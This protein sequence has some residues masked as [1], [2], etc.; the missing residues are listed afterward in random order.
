MRA[1]LKELLQLQEVDTRLNAVRARVAT[2]PQ[3]LAEVNARLAA[4]KA[5]LEKGKESHSTALKDRKKHELDVEQWKEKARKYRD[6]A[7]QVKTNEA[8]KALQHEAEMAEAEIA[9]S[10]DRLL[11]QMVSSEQYDRQVKSA[12]KS[13]KLVEDEVNAQRARIEG[14]KAEAEKE[15]AGF[16]AERAKAV[17]VI[18]EDLVDHY[19]R[20]AKKHG[21]VAVAA[22]R[23]E[24]CGACGAHIRPHVFQEL[25]REDN[26]ELYHCEL[27]TRI[28]YY[29][30]P[31]AAA[32]ATAQ[33]AAHTSE[34]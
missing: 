18:P 29:I 23:G 15:L 27:C 5:Q 21:G 9:K 13:F 22:I 19:Q 26:P 2:F 34:N 25:S 4:G 3:R 31:P 12:E 20:I 10:E 30:E 11:E 17:A 6:Q 8:F 33:A 32:E 7:Y 28:L 14:E 24:A 1:I 16:E